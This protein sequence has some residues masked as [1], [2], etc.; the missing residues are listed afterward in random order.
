MPWLLRAIDQHK[1]ELPAIDTDVRPA[2]AWQC[3]G[4]RAVYVVLDHQTDGLYFAK[5]TPPQ[6]GRLIERGVDL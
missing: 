2:D 3:E 5:A 6:L 1:C 4:C